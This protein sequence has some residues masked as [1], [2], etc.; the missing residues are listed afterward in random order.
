MQAARLVLV[1]ED[2]EPVAVLNVS[3]SELEIEA[4]Y[5]LT[6]IT[7]DDDPEGTVRLMLTT[8]ED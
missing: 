2:D 3:G 7:S 4:E 6:E 5:G 1:N 8:L